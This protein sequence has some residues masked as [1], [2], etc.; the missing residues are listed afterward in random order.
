MSEVQR[1]NFLIERDGL[2]AA[3]DWAC[4]TRGLYRVAVL[5]KDHYA[6]K[7]KYR[8]MFIESYLEFKQF[9]EGNDQW[10]QNI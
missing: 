3:R 10:T 6:S 2:Q 1:L 7:G 8:R 4:R 9:C 5:N